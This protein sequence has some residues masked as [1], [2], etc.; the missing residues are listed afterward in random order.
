MAEIVNLRQARKNKAR[1][2]QEA[3]AAQN[4]VAFG[5]K[6]SGGLPRRSRS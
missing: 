5:R 2:E 6:P 1:A 4:R 3:K